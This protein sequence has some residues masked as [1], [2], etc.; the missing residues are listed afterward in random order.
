M[1]VLAIDYPEV[2]ANIHQV[3]SQT[4]TNISD[5]DLRTHGPAKIT[6]A[7]KAHFGGETIYIPKGY[8]LEIT[9]RHREI[10]EKFN[11]KNHIALAHEY[12][13]TTR[14]IYSIVRT[15]HKEEQALRQRSLFD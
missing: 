13:L 15:I 3:I 11:G 10:Y 9:A 14:Q 5:A 8:E 6:N 4:I 7:I 1:N 12:S 2:L